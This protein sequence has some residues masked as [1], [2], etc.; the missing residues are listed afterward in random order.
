[1]SQEAVSIKG[2]KNGLVIIF[3]PDGD[4]DEIKNKLKMKMETSGG[5]FKG[6]KFTVYAP[7]CDVDHSFIPELEGICRQYGLIPSGEVAWPPSPAREEQKSAPKRKQSRVIPLRQQQSGGEQALLVNR[8][9]RSG[10]RVESNHTVVVMGDVNPGA[11]VISEGSIYVLGS[12]KGSVHAGC[13]GNLMSE[14]FAL[15]LQPLSLR[16]GSIAADG[17]PSVVDGPAAARVNRGK[18]DIGK[19]SVNNVP[20]L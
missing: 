7:G 20:I 12:C 18:I 19:H 15:R 10:Q 16:I 11:E 13:G 8:T 17:S 2:T 5:F 6:A 3:N 9:L 14:V 1:M 4:I